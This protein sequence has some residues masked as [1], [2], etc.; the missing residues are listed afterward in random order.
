MKKSLLIVF[1]FFSS[2]LM[3]QEYCYDEIYLRDNLGKFNIINKEG[4]FIIRNDS[5]YLF[6][7]GLK[8]ISKRLLFDNKQQATGNLY[9]CSDDVYSYTMLLTID[10]DLYFYTNKKEMLK[11]KLKKKQ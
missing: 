3:S 7:Q 6:E 2:K 1:L 8:I 10:D 11:F 5:I 9:S 4:D